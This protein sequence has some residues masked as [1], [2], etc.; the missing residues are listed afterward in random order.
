MLTLIANPDFLAEGKRA[1]LDNLNRLSFDNAKERVLEAL[2]RRGYV[3]SGD[4]QNPVET[5]TTVEVE[6]GYG[7]EK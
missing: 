4:I 5:E 3:P 6:V 2:N 7:T 1:I